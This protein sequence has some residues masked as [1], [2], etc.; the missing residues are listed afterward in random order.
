MF[1]CACRFWSLVFMQDFSVESKTSGISSL[2]T[3]WQDLEARYKSSKEVNMTPRRT[4]T[5]PVKMK[6]SEDLVRK[7]PNLAGQGDSSNLKRNWRQ[8]P[9][10]SWGQT[11]ED[12]GSNTGQTRPQAGPIG[13]P[14]PAGLAHPV[15]PSFDLAA[16]RTIYS[17]EAKIHSRI[18]LSS[19]AK[20][21]RCLRD[22]ISE[23]RVVLVVQGLP[24]RRGN[25]AWKTMSELRSK[26]QDRGR[27]LVVIL[28]M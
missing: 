23:R 26:D 27:I 14:R 10:C 4:R 20:E 28:F 12:S 24:R 15:G 9:T 16:N 6:N 5:E 8:G 18:N 13:R 3:S 25:L 17:P 22:T 11:L 19:A 21:Q 1:V 2:G 7:L